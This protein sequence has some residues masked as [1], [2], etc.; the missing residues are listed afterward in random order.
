MTANEQLLRELYPEK[1]FKTEFSGIREQFTYYE[2]M[3]FALNAQSAT[4]KELQNV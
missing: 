1:D 4:I 2:M 3:D